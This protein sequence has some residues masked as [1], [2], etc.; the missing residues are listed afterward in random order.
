MNKPAEDDAPKKD[1]KLKIGETARPPAQKSAPKKAPAGEKK[2]INDPEEWDGVRKNWAHEKVQKM[3]AY[4]LA[5][6][7][8]DDDLPLAKH[9]LLMAIV[10]F[11]V[12]FVVWA[13]FASLDEVTRGEGKIIPS[14][15]VQA[16][17][18]LDAG[19]VTEMLVR[20]GEEVQAG[21]TLMR[22]NAIEASSDLGA[23]RARY[24]GLL[25][26]ITRL[27]AEAEGKASV[28]FPDEVMKGSPSSV[29]EELNAF[30]ANQQQYMSQRDV[31]QQ[32][33]S[34]REQEV[35][36]LNTRASD[37]RGVIA[38]Q[39]Q[40][41]DMIRPLVTAGSAPKLELLQLERTIKERRPS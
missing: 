2:T 37:A 31:L 33:T 6:F 17:Q 38:L 22:L 32:Q 13:N 28:E 1:L 16:I 23:N 10:S 3:Q 30:R 5:T 18:S 8:T 25:A 39:R 29:T 11:A 34:Q 35:R 15:E 14:S 24:L 21:Q 19:T 27:Q 9:Y 12:V 40:E 41:A 7:E 26:S 20:E 36:E 4:A